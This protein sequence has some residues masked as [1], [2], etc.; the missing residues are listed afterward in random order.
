MSGKLKVSDGDWVCG[1][2]ECGNLNFARRSECNKC[3]A[4]KSNAS[5]VIK[6]S[7]SEIGK[8][9]ASKSKGLFSAEDWQCS[10]CS[11]INW[12]RRMTCNLCN[13]PKLKTQESR[14]G[15]GG[16]FMERDN[17]EYIEREESD[18]EYDEFGRRKR[19]F[20][21]QV[22]AP[23]QKD[24]GGDSKDNEVKVKEEEEDDDD[25]DDEDFDA[26][27]YDLSASDDDDGDS[28]DTS[29]SDERKRRHSSSSSSRSSSSSSS[30]SS[31]SRSRSRSSSRSS[32]SRS[33]SGSRSR[34]P[35]R[36]RR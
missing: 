31:R 23:Q 25:D 21:G 33:R 17:V 1:N 4:A 24:V 34:S 35:K 28:K 9:F 14:T 16:G 15:I 3:G 6:Q 30:S 32:R 29:K 11:N 19:K 8:N 13:A 2:G 10:K 20:R 36:S 12:A 7:G 22:P 5:Q 18:D 27:K 26:S